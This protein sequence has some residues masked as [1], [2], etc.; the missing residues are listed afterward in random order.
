MAGFCV[1]HPRDPER[2]SDP[3]QEHV[4]ETEAPPPAPDVADP[5][6]ALMP[7]S[8]LLLKLG[9]DPEPPGLREALRPLLAHVD[10]DEQAYIR[11]YPDVE[12]AIQANAYSSGRAHFVQHGY[13]EGRSPRPDPV[14]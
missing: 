4:R 9:L 2:P 1:T 8:E 10:V 11:A 14:E 6:I 13:F 3:F 5:A 12:A 7:F